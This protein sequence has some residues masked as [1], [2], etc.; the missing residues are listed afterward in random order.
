[1][2]GIILKRAEIANRTKG[3]FK[4]ALQVNGGQSQWGSVSCQSE[5]F[6]PAAMMGSQRNSERGAGTQH[7]CFHAAK[8]SERMAGLRRP[9]SNLHLLL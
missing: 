3:Q 9:A 8:R 6:D 7:R 5:I 4:I 2:R 1:M